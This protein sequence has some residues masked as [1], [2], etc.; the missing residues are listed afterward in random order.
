ML[1]LSPFTGDVLPLA[2]CK[3]CG[4]DAPIRAS[5][6]D[7]VVKWG[8]IMMVLQV[9]GASTAQGTHTSLPSH[10]L[11]SPVL[12]PLYA[13][14][15]LAAMMLSP[16]THLF[17]RPFSP[18]PLATQDGMI[19]WLLQAV[20]TGEGALPMA[21]AP[22]TCF[23]LTCFA[24][25]VNLPRRLSHFVLGSCEAEFSKKEELADDA[26]ISMYAAQKVAF[27]QST[28]S[29]P[30]KHPLPPPPAA[31][32]PQATVTAS[33]GMGASG[34]G[35]PPGKKPVTPKASVRGAAK[36]GGKAMM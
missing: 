17:L 22:L 32:A 11:Y 36:G 29:V 10:T 1:V 31:T 21:G 4:M 26:K 25:V 28:P 12:S 13:L 15:L 33:S 23:A 3:A 7:G 24:V 5:T 16:R 8:V 19:L 9:G 30:P 14:P 27:K 34:R 6:R 20:H 18:A 2:G 35:L